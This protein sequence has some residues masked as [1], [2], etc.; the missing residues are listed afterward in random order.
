[1]FLIYMLIRL[2]LADQVVLLVNPDMSFLFFDGH[3]YSHPTQN[4]F[5]TLPRHRKIRFCPVWALIDM[6]SEESGPPIN[7]DSLIWPIQA[8]SPKPVRWR[9]WVKQAMAGRFGMPLWT[10][11]E[12]IGGYV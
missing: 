7:D 10:I 3:V 9:A 6:D 2:L 1:M 4:A 12:L 11:E 8:S 5:R